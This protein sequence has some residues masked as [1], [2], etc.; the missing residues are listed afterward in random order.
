[1]FYKQ[2][3]KAKKDLEDQKDAEYKKA[4]ERA[5]TLWES[6]IAANPFHP[7]LVKK[8]ILSFSARQTGADLVLPIIDCNYLIQSLQYIDPHGNK[9]FLS[10]GKKKG[11]FILV[12]GNLSSTGI[13]IAEGF[14]TAATLAT[15]H[16]HMCMLAALDAGNLEPVALSVR[17]HNPLS[18]FG[19]DDRGRDDNPGSTNALQAAIA[20]GGEFY[21]PDWPV[22]APAHLT[23][24]NDL[25]CWL[26]ETNREVADE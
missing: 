6:L 8:R 7:Y 1:M 16:P 21:L 14:A 23:D 26:E 19:D 10:G 22:G 17:R 4:A 9:Y 20:V 24:F 5:R 3:A 18:I 12:K 15:L 25:V 2:I 13:G 11:N